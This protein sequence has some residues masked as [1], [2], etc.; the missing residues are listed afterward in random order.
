[1]N[2]Y[3]EDVEVDEE[4]FEL[5]SDGEDLDCLEE[6]LALSDTDLDSVSDSSEEEVNQEDEDY[7]VDEEEEEEDLEIDELDLDPVEVVDEGYEGC[8]DDELFSE[9]HFVEFSYILYEEKDIQTVR[10]DCER[11]RHFNFFY[12][13]QFIFGCLYVSD[14]REQL[15]KLL[16]YSYK[17]QQEHERGNWPLIKVRE[18]AIL[19]FREVVRLDNVYSACGFGNILKDYDKFETYLRSLRQENGVCSI[20][21]LLSSHQDVSMRMLLSA[22]IMMCLMHRIVDYYEREHLNLCHIPAQFFLCDFAR[23]FSACGAIDDDGIN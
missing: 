18:C 1:M 2:I 20:I 5:S 14:L 7:S 11:M 9:Y 21:K 6:Y 16:V 15:L 13:P 8:L 3:V 10:D 23:S 22:D 19:M 12:Y 17:I 4:D